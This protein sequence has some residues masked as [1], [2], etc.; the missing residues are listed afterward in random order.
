ML[1]DMR[2]DAVA[3][4]H[5]IQGEPMKTGPVLKVCYF[6]SISDDMDRSFVYQ[7]VQFSLYLQSS[8]TGI[9][10]LHRSYI[11]LLTIMS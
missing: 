2:R 3:G 9:L 11:V 6:H 5:Y 4:S 7:V 8:K 1:P 10:I